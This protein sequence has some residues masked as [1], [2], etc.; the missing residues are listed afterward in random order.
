MH[1]SSVSVPIDAT[2]DGSYSH[3]IDKLMFRPAT[4]SP[5]EFEDEDD[6]EDNGE[7]PQGLESDGKLKQVL[8]YSLRFADDERVRFARTFMDEAQALRNPESSISRLARLM[9]TNALHLVSATPTLHRIEDMAAFAHLAWRLAVD[10]GLPHNL[11][12]VDIS[13]DRLACAYDP[14]RHDDGD[15]LTQAI[16]YDLPG[17]RE[18]REYTEKFRRPWW[19]LSPHV[20]GLIGSPTLTHG[21]GTGSTD[22]SSAAYRGVCD[23]IMIRRNMDTAMIL[24]DGSKVF[25]R[26]S[27]MPVTYEYEIHGYKGEMGDSVAEL[28]NSMLR[29]LPVS[30]AGPDKGGLIQVDA[31]ASQGEAEGEASSVKKKKKTAAID[32]AIVRILWMLSMDY[33]SFAVLSC[34]D[35]AS[36][37]GPGRTMSAAMAHLDK[38]GANQ[39]RT[40]L[41]TLP[42]IEE[43]RAAG[44]KD[45]VIP[46]IGAKH[47]EHILENCLDGGLS[48]LWALTCRDPSCV[49]AVERGAMVNFVIAESPVLFRALQWVFNNKLE[50]HRSLVVVNN[51]WMQQ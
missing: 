38:H 39:A 47:T 32:M 8:A 6:P 48:Y 46:T 24:P 42:S 7:V 44:T 45:G 9:P 14:L 21:D 18:L 35:E 3:K 27:M 25:L 11:P 43:S 2:V 12:L 22:I 51:P 30:E 28:V 1:A 40:Q 23:T 5:E 19:C 4:Y 17:A 13:S 49:P 33:R 20:A 16:R 41:P 37:I 15:E 34:D 36:T 26:E 50:K 29:R 31:H 10:G